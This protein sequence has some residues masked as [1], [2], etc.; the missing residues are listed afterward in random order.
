MARTRKTV[1]PVWLEAKQWKSGKE[2]AS[3][4][5]MQKVR[6]KSSISARTEGR[7]SSLR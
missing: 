1:L 3:W 6:I 4:R 2:T 7:T 5:P